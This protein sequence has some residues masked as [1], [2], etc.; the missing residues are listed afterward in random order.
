M[1]INLKVIA[2]SVFSVAAILNFNLDYAKNMVYSLGNG[3]ILFFDHKNVGFASKIK[4]L[5]KPLAEISTILYFCGGHFEFANKKIAQWWQSVINR[6][7][8][9]WVLLYQNQ[10]KNIVCTP[11]PTSASCHQTK[12]NLFE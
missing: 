7:Y 6:I 8:D 11:K 5:C 9:Q 1:S 2:D 4:F 3:S 12:R 10:P